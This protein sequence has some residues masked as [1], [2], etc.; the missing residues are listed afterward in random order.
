MSKL[1]Y[2]L[3]ASNW[4]E[5]LPIGNGFIGGMV[6]GDIIKE[7]LQINE[8]SIWTSSMPNRISE[9]SSEYLDEIRTLLFND[10]ISKA[11]ILAKQSMYA[12]YPHMSHYQ[13]LGDIWI[14]YFTREGDYKEE[15]DEMGIT[16]KVIDLSKNGDYL[17]TLNL[18]NAIGT[19]RYTYNNQTYN[20]EYFASNPG[21]FMAYKI[22]SEKSDLTVGISLARRDNRSGRG[23]SYLDDYLVNNSFLTLRGKTSG[24][25]G[26]NFILKVKVISEGGKQFK[27][28][29]NLIVE[30]AQKI[31]LYISARTDYR[32]KNIEEYCDGILGELK[33]NNYNVLKQKHIN[34]Y[35]S[36]FYKSR[37]NLESNVDDK[38]LTIP[39][40][41][42]KHRAGN[43]VPSLLQTY[44]DYGHYLLIASSREGS[45]PANLQGIWNHEFQP[46]W[47][48]KY[49]ININIEMNYWFAEKSGLSS[50]HLP[51]IQHLKKMFQKGKDVARQM[52]DCR[53]FCCHHNTDI[54]G[55]CAPQD[56]TIG[57][58]LWPM[59]GAWLSLHL[60]EH[61]IYSKDEEFLK[62]Y[63]DIYQE[64]V[65]FF[66]DYMVKN[67]N[68]EWVTGPSVS[69][70]NIYINKY[71]VTGSLT[72]G[73]TMDIEIIR[74]LFSGYL[75][76]TTQF[77][78]EL[79]CELIPKVKERLISLPSLKIGKHGQ[80]Q[81]WNHDY[82][83]YEKGHRHISQLF[84]LYP[85]N[86]IKVEKTPELAKA[87]EKT[88]KRR[89]SFG[90]GHTGWSQAWI[91][92]LW[93]Q[94]N[95]GTQAFKHLNELLSNSTQMNLLDSHPPFQIDG[96]FGGVNGIYEMLVRD[97][98][99]SIYLLPAI[100]ED[101]PN[102]SL[103]GYVLK[104]GGTLDIKWNEGDLIYVKIRNLRKK[105]TLYFNG[106]HEG[107]K[108]DERE[109]EL[110]I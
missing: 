77:K 54:W 29:G 97:T 86:S 81:E 62:E 89:L 37:L 99:E 60:L 2:R 64:S 92:N 100:T 46:P 75:Y 87:A 51:L 110:K 16:R 12:K 79:S 106:Q 48:S 24:S 58:T 27:R 36:Y 70:E 13:T 14:D 18:E 88:L 90:G 61:Y 66:I 45:L 82:E 93:A 39:D 3:P 52:Y 32:S 15:V 71:G 78:N 84:A 76:L 31:I 103:E 30:N 59:G 4:E 34:D 11:E 23:A 94:L 35:Q 72:M 8:D 74:E 44:F 80:I 9:E 19:V 28:G 107:I 109:F 22:E 47:G 1:K 95:K 104:N 50:L 10:E 108:I 42:I 17:R 5:A 56:Q 83:E 38:D 85:G 98:G 26:I 96:N 55:D 21:N 57:A 25:K 33:L 67:G 53:G 73:P 91:I 102:G 49:T 105:I 20:N 40:M 7:R 41:L 69:P 65:L 63:F 101:F 6:Y 68:N 43:I